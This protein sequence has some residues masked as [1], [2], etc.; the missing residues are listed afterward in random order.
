MAEL[1]FAILQRLASRGDVPPTA[2]EDNAST[3]EPAAASNESRRGCRF[4]AQGR[5]TKGDA[6][7]FRHAPAG[8]L[9][10]AAAPAAAR[11]P[12]GA[13]SA[14]SPPPPPPSS[15]WGVTSIARRLLRRLASLD[16]ERGDDGAA[17]AEE[18][19]EPD[20]PVD[21]PSTLAGFGAVICYTTPGLEV[22][23][24]RGRG[25]DD[26]PTMKWHLQDFDPLEPLGS[27]DGVAR[28]E[29]PP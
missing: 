7:P 20:E 4:Y 17:A 8:A 9:P 6:C 11:A 29:S 3:P 13:S 2:S 24:G 22:G 5:C 26:D 10:L 15:G 12:P 21:A 27:R 16:D 19:E 28:L 23:G 14:L 25:E 18:E 1:G